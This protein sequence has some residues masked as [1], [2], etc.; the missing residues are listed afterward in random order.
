VTTAKIADANVTT[1]K[2]ANNS[3]TALKLGTNEQ[4]QICKTWV[5]FN[6]SGV[7]L[8][9]FNVSSVVRNSVGNYTVNFSA[10]LPDANYAV[11]V[12]TANSIVMGAAITST[13]SSVRVTAAR[14]DIYSG[15]DSECFVTVF[16]N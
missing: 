1:V 13:T 2:L 11:S 3:V 10:A 7:V 14:V 16:G 4:K 5:R 15:F 8:S 12:T 6:A 9:S